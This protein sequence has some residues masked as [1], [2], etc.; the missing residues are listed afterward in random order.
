MA[1]LDE[2]QVLNNVKIDL[3]ISDNLQDDILKVLLKRVVDHFKAEYQ[4]EE[5][6]DKYSFIFE[7]CVI[8]RFNR[9]GSEGAQSE[10]VEGHSVSYYDNKNEFIPYDNMLQKAFGTSGQ[11]SVGSVMFL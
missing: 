6:D 7:D 5:I 4:V 11:A 8:K 2:E 3:D 9:R 1:L 10:S